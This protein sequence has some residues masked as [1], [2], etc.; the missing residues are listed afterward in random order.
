VIKYIVC[1]LAVLVVMAGL[2]ETGYR[3]GWDAHSAKV[4]RDYQDRQA[5]LQRQQ[6]K[7]TEKAAR[8]DAAGEQKTE[9]IYRDVVKYIKTGTDA[10]CNFSTDRVQLKQRAVANANTIEGYD[11]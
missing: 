11:N 5:K 9:V 6:A 3:Q 8:A 1:T 7:N 10:K 2:L 4:N